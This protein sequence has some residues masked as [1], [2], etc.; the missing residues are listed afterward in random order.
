MLEA[1]MPLEGDGGGMP[2]LVSVIINCY[3][4][5]EYLREA[6]DS[7]LAQTYPHWEIIFWDNASTDGSATIARSYGDQ[8][9]YFRSATTIPLYEARNLALNYCN[10]RATGF[11]DCDDIWLPDKL[12]QQVALFLEGKKIVYGRYE[13]IDGSGRRTGVIS[14]DPVIGWVT[15]SLLRRNVISIGTLLIDTELLRSYRFDPSFFLVGD[16]ELW[17]RLSL[18]HPFH[19]L[20]GIVELSRQHAGNTSR[21]LHSRW[22]P[23]RRRFYRQ[24][25]KVQSSLKYPNILRYI[26]RAEVR[27]ALGRW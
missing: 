11:L 13:E 14:P 15:D 16:F 21:L 7:V 20:D 2:L 27:G 1:C 4:G 24:F 17:V 22:L 10:G 9:R 3:N 18:D 19:S 12:E 8:V 5:E 23:E 25:L 6:I 26:V